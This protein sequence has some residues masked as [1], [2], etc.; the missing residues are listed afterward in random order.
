MDLTMNIN[1]TPNMEVVRR[2]CAMNEASFCYMLV[3]YSFKHIVLF[4]NIHDSLLKKATNELA[5]WCGMS[6]KI[7]NKN[8]RNST[9]HNIKTQGE[10]ILPIIF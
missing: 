9:I 8:S 2:I 1:T 5:S 7:H 3:D 6:F 10:K 4:R